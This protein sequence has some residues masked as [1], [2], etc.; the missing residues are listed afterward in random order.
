M[1]PCGQGAGP[2]GRSRPYRETADGE[3]EDAPQQNTDRLSGS[4]ASRRDPY[5]YSPCRD[6]HRRNA[7]WHRDDLDALLRSLLVLGELRRLI[8]HSPQQSIH[9]GRR[10][11]PGRRRDVGVNVHRS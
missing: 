2:E 4:T 9:C 8:S 7:L 5:S 11:P 10:F 1:G 6:F 3:S